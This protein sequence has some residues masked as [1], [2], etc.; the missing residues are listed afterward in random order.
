MARV[1]RPLLKQVDR[2]DEIPE[3]QTE[4]EEA[5]FWST[6]RFSDRMLEQMQPLPADLLPPPRPRRAPARPRPIKSVDS[7]RCSR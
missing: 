5:E 4:A 6:H 3:F 2:L 7:G 1:R